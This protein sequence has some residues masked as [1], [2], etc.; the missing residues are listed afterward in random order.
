MA[1]LPS[2]TG[3]SYLP[4]ITASLLRIYS[5]ISL[6]SVQ[7]MPTDCIGSWL[8]YH[9]ADTVLL[10]QIASCAPLLVLATLLTVLVFPID[11][12]SIDIVAL[13]QFI[14]VGIFATDGNGTFEWD[15]WPLL[16]G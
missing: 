6:V 5:N 14:Y 16:Q 11:F 7:A 13:S 12:F 15:C 10:M 9:R 8:G 2:S 4:P 3:M 1:S